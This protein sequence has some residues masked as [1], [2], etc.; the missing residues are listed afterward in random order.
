MKSLAFDITRAQIRE[1]LKFDNRSVNEI[2]EAVAGH[3]AR[4]KDDLVMAWVA[5]TGIKPSE[6]VICSGFMPDGTHRIFVESK[7]ENDKRAHVGV[8]PFN[9]IYMAGME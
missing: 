9:K 6:A 8:E 2:M 1:E 3:I 7:T 4:K 5:E